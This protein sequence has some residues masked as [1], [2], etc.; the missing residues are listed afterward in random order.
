MNVSARAGLLRRLFTLAFAVALL[1]AAFGSGRTPVRAAG[2]IGMDPAHAAALQATLD[3]VRSELNV[4]GLSLAIRLPDGTVWNA[5]S[6]EGQVAPSIRAVTPDM[7]FSAG[8]I[9][10]TFVAA[11][12][13]QEVEQGVIHLADRVSR[14]MPGWPNG[15]HIRIHQLLS[16][17]SGLFDYFTNPSFESLVFGRPTHVWTVPEILRLVGQPIAAPGQR[18]S[19]SNTNYV[20]LG[21][22]LQRATHQS[23]GTLI[24]T[25]LLAP[26]GLDQTEFQ[27]VEPVGPDAALGYLLG[28]SRWRTV[29]DQSPYRPNASAATVAWAAG[30]ILS[31]PSDLVRWGHALYAEGTVVSAES[32]ASMTVFNDG[33]Y[34]LGTERFFTTN[35]PAT[36]EPMWGHSGSLRG[37]EAQLWYVPSRDV[38]ISLLSNRGRVSVRPAVQQLLAVLFAAIDPLP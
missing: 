8:S 19:Y 38:T 2:A 24:R 30:A 33:E 14:W 6:G 28:K 13:M 26:L 34:G 5:V 25:R 27:D 29:A 15:A 3:Q 32:L 21:R 35:D 4:P 23:L 1:V 20:L 7:P 18:F 31:T 36:Q 12:V 11:L 37:F 22:I 10:K 16:H 17:R 9:T